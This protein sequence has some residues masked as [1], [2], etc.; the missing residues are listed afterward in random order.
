M[1]I[2]EVVSPLKKYLATVR[3]S[4]TMAKTLIDAESSS[5]A[6]LLLGKM[7]GKFNVVSVSCVHLDETLIAQ[8]LP[9]QAK[10]AEVINNLTSQITSNAN[11]LQPTQKDIEIAVNRYKTNQ[12]RA[13]REY[14]DKRRLR[15]LR[16]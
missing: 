4:G 14:E 3:V 8:P 11:K 10:H 15:S 2:N 16:H 1:R 13:N 7:Y 5:H 9:S 6:T 12:K